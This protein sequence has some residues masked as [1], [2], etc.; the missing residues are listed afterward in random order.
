MRITLPATP[1]ATPIA[2]A[3]GERRETVWAQVLHSAHISKK[4]MAYLANSPGRFEYV[5]PPNHGSWL[6]PVESSL[7]K[8]ARSF[9]R[10]MRVARSALRLTSVS[11]DLSGL[12]ASDYCNH[13]RRLGAQPVVRFNVREDNVSFAPDDVDGR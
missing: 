3:Q 10:H 1:L 6:N 5:H 7:S 13:I 12:R 9:L 11:A 4:T 8:M 2:R